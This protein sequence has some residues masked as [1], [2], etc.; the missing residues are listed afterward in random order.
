MVPDIIIKNLLNVIALMWALNADAIE[1]P[2]RKFFR[3]EVKDKHS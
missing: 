2:L 3:P 1:S